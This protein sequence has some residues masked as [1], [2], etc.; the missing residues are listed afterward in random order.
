MRQDIRSE[1]AQALKRKN[2]S[3]YEV[4]ERQDLA[5][6]INIVE[7]SRFQKMKIRRLSEMRNSLN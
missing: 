4:Y 3:L 2:P 6:G 1:L 7:F 5:M